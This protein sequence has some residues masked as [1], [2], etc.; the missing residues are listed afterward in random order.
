VWTGGTTLKASPP[1]GRCK[2]Q[3]KPVAISYTWKSK[4][5]SPDLPHLPR[6]QGR[7]LYSTE[8]TTYYLTSPNHMRLSRPSMTLPPMK[9]THF[10]WCWGHWRRLS[11]A[12]C[13]CVSGVVSQ[14]HGRRWHFYCIIFLRFLSEVSRHGL[15]AIITSDAGHSLNFLGGG[16]KL[17][18]KPRASYVLSTCWPLSYNLS[19]LSGFNILQLTHG[20]FLI[21]NS[22]VKPLVSYNIF[23]WSFYVINKD[24]CFWALLKIEDEI[25]RN[26]NSDWIARNYW[27]EP[28]SEC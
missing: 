27:M 18:I 2:L 24:T 7:H 8:L 17:K 19:L 5:T 23:W 11:L 3:L 4:K 22:K 21:I 10:L 15:A 12:G 16:G 28:F 1:Q 26:R 20:I 14:W 6:L 25:K 13:K 9:L